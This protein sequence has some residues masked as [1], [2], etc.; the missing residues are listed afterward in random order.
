MCFRARIKL[1]GMLLRQEY[2]SWECLLGVQ[3]T[4]G[5][6]SRDCTKFM[7]MPL[8]IGI[9]SW[10]CTRREN[11]I[12]GNA[13]GNKVHGN[14]SQGGNKIYV[15]ALRAGIK[16]MRMPIRIAMNS[17]ECIREG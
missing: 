17:W 15:N 6:A 9:N 1:I 12:H 2:C 13:C 11:I 8:G 7:G 4:H 5:N 10:E 3:K 14:A 16:S